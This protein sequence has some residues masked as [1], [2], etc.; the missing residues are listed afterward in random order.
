MYNQKTC[1]TQPPANGGGCGSCGCGGAAPSVT[2]ITPLPF[3]PQTIQF[4]P[5]LTHEPASTGGT[6]GPT[7]EPEST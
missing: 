4:V 7:Y 5:G 2:P 3:N 6:S 1:G